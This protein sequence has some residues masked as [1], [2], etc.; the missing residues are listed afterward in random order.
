MRHD[1]TKLHKSD[2]FMTS[3]DSESAKEYNNFF[4]FTFTV[5]KADSISRTYVLCQPMSLTHC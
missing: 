4:K 1:I 2:G 3:S 5:E